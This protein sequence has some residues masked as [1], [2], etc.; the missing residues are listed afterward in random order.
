MPGY[1]TKNYRIR[2]P[3]ENAHQSQNKKNKG[4]VEYVMKV[5]RN[6]KRLK[7]YSEVISSLNSYIA[8]YQTQ[9]PSACPTVYIPTPVAP[10]EQ[11]AKANGYCI[12]RD[13]KYWRC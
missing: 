11:S 13:D 3:I 7:K 8:E 5:Y 10:A 1:I 6:I 4:S 12:V 2:L 9:S